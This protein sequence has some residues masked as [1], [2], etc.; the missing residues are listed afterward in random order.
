MDYSIGYTHVGVLVG[1]KSG[2]LV[3]VD[4]PAALR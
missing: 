2:L 4:F 1:D 3:S